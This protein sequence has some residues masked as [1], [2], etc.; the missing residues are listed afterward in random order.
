MGSLVHFNG[1]VSNITYLDLNNKG[2]KCSTIQ[3]F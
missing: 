2:D 3:D 1:Y